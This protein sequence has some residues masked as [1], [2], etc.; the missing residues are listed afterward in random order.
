MIY[1]KELNLPEIPKE[2]LIFPDKPFKVVNDIGY[3]SI[4]IKEGKILTGCQYMNYNIEYKPLL[5]WLHNNIAGSN[6]G[7]KR[8]QVSKSLDVIGTH[9]VHS[10]IKRVFAL[11]YLLELGGDNVLTTWYKERNKPLYRYKEQ[12][13][14]QSDNGVVK[15]DD[16]E[17]LTSVKFKK[18]K[19]CLLAT[20]ILHD[21]DNITGERSAISISFKNRNILKLLGIEDV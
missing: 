12:T 16:L 1:Y 15:Y 8:K 6:L 4:H 13:G 14:Q 2:L 20:D 7:I 3:G 19:W 10:D 21:V 18:H 17:V 11:N 9:I 5:D